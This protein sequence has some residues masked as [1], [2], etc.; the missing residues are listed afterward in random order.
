MR[1]ALAV[2]LLLASV[3][4]A[5]AARV[6]SGPFPIG[7]P[8]ARQTQVAVAPDGTRVSAWIEPADVYS[9]MGLDYYGPSP[10]FAAVGDHDPVAL[11]LGN[12]TGP[13]LA[14]A[15]G[16]AMVAWTSGSDTPNVPA[17]RVAFPNADGTV[18][19]PVQLPAGFVRAAAIND[20]GQA[21]VIAEVGTYPGA[22]DA[23]F[24]KPPGGDFGPP[25]EIPGDTG[26][27]VLV[28]PTGETVFV[29]YGNYDT[30]IYSR[31]IDGTLSAP[32]AMP[33]ASAV[34][35]AADAAGHV[36]A[37]SE[38]RDT[39]AVRTAIRAPDGTW[40]QSTIATVHG[41]VPS[42]AVN[43]RGDAVVAWLPLAGD[44]TYVMAG[45]L[46]DGALPQPVALTLGGS[47]LETTA[48]G[49]DGS[50]ILVTSSPTEPNVLTVARRDGLGP[51]GPAE[52][53]DCYAEGAGRALALDDQGHAVVS[54][55]AGLLYETT[56]P[57]ADPRTCE[58][59]GFTAHP[60][61]S[62]DHVFAGE[63]VTVDA[64][65][66]REHDT[67]V[68]AA[69]F[70]F[71]DDGAT[72]SMGRPDAIQH[73][74]PTAGQ[75]H[76]KVKTTQKRRYGGFTGSRRYEFNVDVY[77]RAALSAPRVQRRSRVRERGLFVRANAEASR[78]AA[79]VTLTARS[80]GRVL[81]RLKTLLDARPHP[82]RLRLSHQP[83]RV[84]VVLAQGGRVRETR[85]VR[86]R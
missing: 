57:T 38:D 29:S 22:R 26:G 63:P 31:A 82:L 53:A 84:K 7:P 86:L 75:S 11:G 4:P 47:G 78:V 48:V 14:A 9:S 80:G 56:V 24:V 72:H 74:F 18:P 58:P 34:S 10:L 59:A 32:Y 2:A 1:V 37:V 66:A 5:E 17:A 45:S 69:T 67:N 46:A 33:I 54:D 23:L 61:Y 79:P 42:A 50:A 44:A 39:S 52:I 6:W 43:A 19:A 64:S 35:L 30:D 28:T 20:A 12:I 40:G 73:T 27:S 41:G 68:T 60:S 85:T 25:T 70:R 13:L 15:R 36:L 51:F 8:A 71:D 83:K 3:A 81:A 76:W 49:A 55:T 65:D 77:V 16:H 21:A 62:E